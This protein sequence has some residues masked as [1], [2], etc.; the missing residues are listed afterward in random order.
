[1][2]I[3]E[4]MEAVKPLISSGFFQATGEYAST[5]L[6]P[7]LQDSTSE[8]ETENRDRDIKPFRQKAATALPG[9]EFFFD[10]YPAG[11]RVSRE[12]AIK[13]WLKNV[14]DDSLYPEVLAALEMWKQTDQWQDVQFVPEMTTFLNQKRWQDE[15]PKRGGSK[16]EQ[17]INRTVEAARNLMERGPEVD[18]GIG[19][20]LPG[21]TVGTRVENILR[22]PSKIRA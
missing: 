11:R 3:D 17:R 20:A 21:G 4:L 10:A 19:S 8:T 14:R 7:C 16:N 18:G 22:V 15:A 13:A 5:M 12:R 2:P 9:F 1:M 6:A